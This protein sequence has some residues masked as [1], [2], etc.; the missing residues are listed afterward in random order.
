VLEEVDIVGHGIRCASLM[1]DCAKARVRDRLA[2]RVDKAIG[3]EDSERPSPERAYGRIYVFRHLEFVV[4]LRNG[5][6][7]VHERLFARVPVVSGERT[8]KRRGFGAAQLGI[9]RPEP[10]PVRRIVLLLQK[11]Q[12]HEIADKPRRDH[13]RAELVANRTRSS[14]KVLELC[15][16][17]PV[18]RHYV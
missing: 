13:S 2:K 12:S 6:A 14:Q 9:S 3:E 10:L 16:T 18:P 4:P 5:L 7:R 15:D 17:T 1:I 8:G 11:R